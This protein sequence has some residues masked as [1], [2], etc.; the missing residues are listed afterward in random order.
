M[1]GEI[2]VCTRNRTDDMA[3]LLDNLPAQQ[4]R[5]PL[6]VIDSSDGSETE[7]LV[8]AFSESGGWPDVRYL[9]SEPG[10]TKQRMVGIAN[11]LTTTDVVHFVDDD[12]VLQPSYFSAIEA[13]FDR[14]ANC[15]GV[16][17]W[18]TNVP[19]HHPRWTARL[20]GLDS[21]RQGLV[22]PSG[23][24]TFVFEPGP[25]LKVDWLS[26]AAM[27]YRRLVFETISF[28]T[29]MSGYSLGE[30]LDFSFR[31]GALGSLFV[32]GGA[33]LEHLLSPVNRYDARRFSCQ[34]LV[35]RHAFVLAQRE[36]GMSVLAFWWS[37]MGDMVL[38]SLKTVIY[39][40]HDAWHARLGGLFDGMRRIARAEGRP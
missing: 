30:D 32:T 37:V 35:R 27:S 13:V 28:D 26:G 9:V 22:L 10:L 18:I 14:D 31:A 21:R 40:D 36:R 17:G 5:P 20:F 29:G 1:T 39:S 15:V 7:E 3:R 4:L 16:G 12:V 34:A 11:L 19:A 33:R 23:T 24:N 38:T 8:R 6:L 2:V 25:L